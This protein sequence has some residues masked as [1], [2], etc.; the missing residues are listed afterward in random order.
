MSLILRTTLGVD[1]VIIHAHFAEEE[2]KAQRGCVTSPGHKILMH[3]MTSTDSV[4][5][6]LAAS[7]LVL[8]VVVYM[9]L[10]FLPAL[11]LVPWLYLEFSGLT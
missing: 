10:P 11:P 8:H 5:W 6:E 3:T 9:A 7:A 4:P 2:S 1:T